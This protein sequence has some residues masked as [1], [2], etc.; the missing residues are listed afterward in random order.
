MFS[1]LF[2]LFMA[3]LARFTEIKTQNVNKNRVVS[4]TLM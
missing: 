1:A 2:S 3:A 4:I